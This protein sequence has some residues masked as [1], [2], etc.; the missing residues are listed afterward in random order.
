MK[1]TQL[2]LAIM[3][4]LSNLSPLTSWAEETILDTI[5]VTARE[6]MLA[7][8]IT[9]DE[10]YS[11]P[12]SFFNSVQTFSRAD[13]LSM[14]AVRTAFDVLDMATS[15]FVQTQ[16]RKSPYFVSMRAGSNLGIILDG[17][18]IPSHSA[19]KILM[20]LPI[21]AIEKVEI[22]RDSSALN[23][24]PL[25]APIGAMTDNRTEGFVVITTRSALS[26]QNDVTAKMGSNALAQVGVSQ[27]FDLGNGDGIRATVNH[28]Q[29]DEST[30]SHNGDNQS[31]AY[32]RASH[33]N[34][35]SWLDFNVFRGSGRTDLQRSSLGTS[36]VNDKW[37]YDPADVSMFALQGGKQWSATQTTS[38][39][40]AYT[41][42]DAQLD[43][44]SYANSSFGT[45]QTR[46]TFSSVDVNHAMSLGNHRVRVGFNWLEWKNPTGMLHWIGIPVAEH[47]R[48]LYAQDEVRLGRW[49][50]DG[51][52]RV[53]NRTLDQNYDTVGTKKVPFNDRA[54]D[55]LYAVSVGASYRA[56][57]NHN[58][59]AR[60]LYTQ[61]QTVG[62]LTTNNASLPKETRLRY[63]LAWSKP[64][65][66]ALITRATV[67]LDK[68]TDA[69]FVSGQVND[70]YHAGQKLNVY[71]A[72]S[73][74]NHGLELAAEGRLEHVFY[75]LSYSH[76]VPGDI[77]TGVVN[78]PGNLVKARL[79]WRDG[80]WSADVTSRYMDKFLSANAA[81]TGY[82]GDFTATDARVA[83]SFKQDENTTHTVGLF[84]RNLADN[85]YVTVYGFPDEGRVVGIDYRLAY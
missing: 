27:G 31:A 76:I 8:G 83:R 36:M 64:W 43:K 39:R 3:A 45:E 74:D 5:E 66:T 49:T 41:T 17:A 81:G 61:Q 82:A 71:G 40:G 69:A 73:R 23:L 6:K 15:V 65:M 63:E 26:K 53:D 18:M 38:I 60:M 57:G 11:V 72:A 32:L 33:T 30:G 1:N 2:A 70:P 59:T 29:R 50:F 77:P 58:Y 85:R 67:F 21:S 20:N 47:S 13:I 10:M 84:V 42:S 68:L 78:T 44:Y 56:E 62:V 46:E 24:G 52:I 75:Q 79:G 7:N 34:T 35:S 54:L 55:P 16:G 4:V 9:P 12:E 37:S 25:S 19:P 28:E 14:P 51:G 80:A 22:V 48:S